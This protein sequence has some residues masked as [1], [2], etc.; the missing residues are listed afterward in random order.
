MLTI[1]TA[2][3]FL[4]LFTTLSWAGIVP[5]ANTQPTN[6]EEHQLARMRREKLRGATSSGGDNQGS[7]S[8]KLSGCG[9]VNIGNLVENK[10]SIGR[11]NITVIVQGP[12]VNS[13]NR[14]R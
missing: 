6:I 10:R 4:T 1:R 11:K 14:C 13:N 2:F 3:I 7:G 12:V 8:D 5:I 9:S